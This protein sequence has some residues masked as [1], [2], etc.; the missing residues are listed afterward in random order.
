MLAF[1]QGL[2]KNTFRH[3]AHR[4]VLESSHGTGGGQEAALAL[5]GN[6]DH[7]IMQRE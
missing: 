6:K 1:T 3:A 4:H 2:A 5:F 7:L